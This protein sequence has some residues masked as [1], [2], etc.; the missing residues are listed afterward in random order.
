MGACRFAKA[1]G[2]CGGE[3][4]HC[5]THAADLGSAQMLALDYLRD[6]G[7]FRVHQFG[8]RERLFGAGGDRGVAPRL[9]PAD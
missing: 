9:R 8:K 7:V 3:K 5:R 2:C 6:G 4:I 1:S